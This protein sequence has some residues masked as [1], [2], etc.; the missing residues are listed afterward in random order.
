MNLNGILLSEALPL[1][2]ALAG[3]LAI[4][5]LLKLRR[6]RIT[7]PFTPLWA[8]V[9]VDK[10][11]SNWIQR[12]KRLLSL[13]L[14]IGIMLL[15]IIALL[16]PR[17]EKELE[18]G[19]NILVLIDTSASMDAKEPSEKGMS[20][21]GLAKRKVDELIDTLGP[22][23]KM[24]L[25]AV[26]GQIRS[27]TGDFTDNV[28]VLNDALQQLRPSATEAR[29]IDGLRTAVDTLS[30]RRDP[31]LY[32][33]SDGAFGQDFALPEKLIRPDIH[34]EHFKVGEETGN[35]AI[36]G[37]NI[38]RYLSNKLDYEVYIQARS[39]FS[40]P[41]FA[42]LTL[43][44]LLPD[45][46]A[47]KGFFFKVIEKRSLDLG[48]G[49]SELRFYKNLAL[50]SEH[51]AVT[52]ELKSE[53]IVDA[54]DMDNEA[55][56]LVPRFQQSRILLVSPGNLFLEA[57]L[58]LNEN[59]IVETL[60]PDD[61]IL[62]P[63]GSAEIR[64]TGLRDKGYDVF[65]FD[66]SFFDDESLPVTPEPELPGNYLYINPKGEK[67]PFNVK[68]I[69]EPLIE[70]IDRK[71]PLAR[72]LV[73]KDLNIIRGSRIN[74]TRED[75]VVVRSVDGPL[76]VARRSPGQN[77]IGVGFSLVESDIVFRV[78]L[79]VFLINAVDWFMDESNSLIQAFRSGKN[80]HI[81]V[82]A[83][84]TAVDVENPFGE[85]DSNV[86][87]HE[88]QVV[89]YGA[90]TGFYKLRPAE[91]VLRPPGTPDFWEIAAHF[92]SVRES[93]ITPMEEPQ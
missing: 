56:V 92:S 32:F 26:D 63:N 87:T 25:M 8:R 14:W 74:A 29:I 52:L 37:F 48:P 50:A 71:H 73:L 57:A 36:T 6:R 13:L 21:F 55:Y 66:N 23:D 69:S 44:N 64:L 83:G 2:G 46:K 24:M 30:E 61:P 15:L 47:P 39:F 76:I 35:I 11:A 53:G 93:N 49:A 75:R 31:T 82:P 27:L 54:L 9:L 33:I 40:Q 17:P 88:S 67:S 38:R 20:R 51:L 34:F 5:Y 1:A 58:L 19:R 41:V 81:N 89:Y 10:N 91:N 78:A 70:R 3:A 16:D 62:H 45:E 60:S 68:A 86:P 18:R 79:P 90:H 4:L 22:H 12:L 7:V 80:W 28:A 85:V 72:W 84:L 43:Y 65:I 77:L 42:E 59:F